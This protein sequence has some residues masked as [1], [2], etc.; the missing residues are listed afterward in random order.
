MN[1][2]QFNL[3]PGFHPKGTKTPFSVKKKSLSFL[4]NG[5]LNER[6]REEWQKYVKKQ[7]LIGRLGKQL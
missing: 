7:P 6:K 5:F 2:L 4:E 1:T 3:P